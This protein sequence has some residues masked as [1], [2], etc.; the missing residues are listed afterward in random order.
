MRPPK[1]RCFYFVYVLCKVFYSI[2]HKIKD[3]DVYI[4]YYGRKVMTYILVITIKN[5]DVYIRYYTIKNNL[6]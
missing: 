2:Y 4:S 3:Y 1:I 6:A 5:Y